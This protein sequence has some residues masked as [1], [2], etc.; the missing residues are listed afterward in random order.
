MQQTTTTA[1]ARREGEE[2]EDDV[3]D[4]SSAWPVWQRSQRETWWRRRWQWQH[5][6][7]PFWESRE[8]ALP[9]PTIRFLASMACS[10]M[11]PCPEC[12]AT[13]QH[14]V[15]TDLR[16]ADER[17]R[18]AGLEGVCWSK[19]PNGTA[20]WHLCLACHARR[21]PHDR[22]CNNRHSRPAPPWYHLTASSL[23]RLVAGDFFLTSPPPEYAEPASSSDRIVRPRL[24]GFMAPAAD[25]S[26]SSSSDGNSRGPDLQMADRVRWSDDWTWLKGG[27]FTAEECGLVAVCPVPDGPRTR[28]AFAHEDLSS[29]SCMAAGCL[30][31]CNEYAFVTVLGVAAPV[32]QRDR[33]FFCRACY[34][35]LRQVSVAGGS[36]WAADIEAHVRV[37]L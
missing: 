32:L 35:R 3:G 13:G 21:Y 24:E 25:D 36:L 22:R 6:H 17:E 18:W 4:S 30:R 15:L 14:T 34:Q 27:E 19:R 2:D 10:S 31:A 23:R 28:C 7:G 20:Y 5:G 37:L 11:P 16:S 8:P 26:S 12:L 29:A 1:T 9:F 33:V